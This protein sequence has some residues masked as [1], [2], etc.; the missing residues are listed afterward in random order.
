VATP[1]MGLGVFGLA[2]DGALTASLVV[3]AALSAI[4]AVRVYSLVITPRWW[5]PKDEGIQH[6]FAE[7]PVRPSFELPKER[8][9]EGGEGAGR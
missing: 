7:G 3:S 2:G 1:I 5:E 6:A 9:E 8:R 4:S